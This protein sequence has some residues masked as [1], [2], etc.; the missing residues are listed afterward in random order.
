[1]LL[2]LV[3]LARGGDVRASL[4]YLLYMCIKL[5]LCMPLMLCKRDFFIRTESQKTVVLSLC[6]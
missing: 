1:M 4:S 2:L 3:G 6:E 5:M